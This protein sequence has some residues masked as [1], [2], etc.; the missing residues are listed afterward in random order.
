MEGS[1]LVPSK[2]GATLIQASSRQLII[3]NHMQ[4]HQ[5]TVVSCNEVGPGSNSFD[6]INGALQFQTGIRRL[7]P[8]AMELGSSD[9]RS[10]ALSSVRVR[11]RLQIKFDVDPD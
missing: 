6:G 9:G 2:D 7:L 11:S 8:R 5:S 4:Q 3:I 1:S 10:L